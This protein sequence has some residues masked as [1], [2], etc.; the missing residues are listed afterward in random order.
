MKLTRR[1]LIR[2]GAAGAGLA[3][4]GG[5]SPLLAE[6]SEL[7]EVTVPSSGA[8][9]P[10]VE[11][12]TGHEPGEFAHTGDAVFCL[13]QRWYRRFSSPRLK[14]RRIRCSDTLFPTASAS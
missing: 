9:L 7:I 11:L 2:M 4:L 10:A 6:T 8:R 3:A 12:L 1:D 5:V 14:A 13:R